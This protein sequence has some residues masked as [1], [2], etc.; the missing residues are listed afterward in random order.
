MQ[1]LKNKESAFTIV[2]LLILLSSS[3]FLRQLQ[4]LRLL[5]LLARLSLPI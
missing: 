5:A 3:E 4:S 1:S 2:E